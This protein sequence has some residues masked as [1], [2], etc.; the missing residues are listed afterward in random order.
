[1][2]KIMFH[3]LA[4]V[5]LM[6]GFAG[7]AIASEADC[8]FSEGFEESEYAVAAF[9]KFGAQT[10]AWQSS[11]EAGEVDFTG[12]IT[13]LKADV[14]LREQTSGGTDIITL[15]SGGAEKLRMRMTDSGAELF[16]NGDALTGGSSLILDWYTVK[17]I[18]YGGTAAQV[19]IDEREV[20]PLTHMEQITAAQVKFGS[21]NMEKH[22]MIDNIAVEKPMAT[23][24]ESAWFLKNGCPVFHLTDG[25]YSVG[26]AV[27]GFGEGAK[28]QLISALYDENN[29][30]ISVSGSQQTEVGSGE[31]A[32]LT[33]EIKVPENSGAKRLAAYVWNAEQHPM[34]EVK[35]YGELRRRERFMIEYPCDGS[36]YRADNIK[37]MS[38]VAVG[39]KEVKFYLNGREYSPV[40]GNDGRYT[41]EAGDGNI[42]LGDNLFSVTAYGEDGSERVLNSAFRV[43]DVLTYI[44]N[45]YHSDNGTSIGKIKVFWNGTDWGKTGEVTGSSG[46]EGDT[47]AKYA[48]GSAASGRNLCIDVSNLSKK[49][50]DDSFRSGRAVLCFD[51]MTENAEGLYAAY[52][53]RGN[54]S[55]MFGTDYIIKD[56]CAAGNDDFRVSDGEWC[57]F[58]LVFDYTA[59]RSE[60]YMNNRLVSGAPFTGFSDSGTY[61]SLMRIMF[62]TGVSSGLWKPAELCFDNIDFRWEVPSDIISVES[63]S[64]SAYPAGKMFFVPQEASEIT[65]TSSMRFTDGFFEGGVQILKN[66][67]QTA[68]AVRKLTDNEDYLGEGVS[69]TEKG[70]KGIRGTRFALDLPDGLSPGD[71]LQVIIPHNTALIATDW[72]YTSDSDTVIL[73]RGFGILIKVF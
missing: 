71:E 14:F 6:A 29:R 20:I 7:G 48:E 47:A 17:L 11:A 62:R 51:M 49:G 59:Q 18:I 45:G 9:D 10:K 61:S 27:Y 30:L 26:A 64:G 36:E 57:S 53:F 63:D 37:Q 15:T 28:A 24:A 4:S 67:V 44:K 21:E 34:T 73:R 65:V 31:A 23:K 41:A 25:E 13:V 39:A 2:K 60:L 40:I 22:C 54:V 52:N 68:A 33:A 66:G 32:F 42:L 58:K 56:G 5:L 8:I 12:G 19:F 38:V 69:E 50:H 70:L 46:A 72:G 16:I 3:L 55:G 1:M 35:E 43:S